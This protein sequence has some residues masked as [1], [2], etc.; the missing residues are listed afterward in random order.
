MGTWGEKPWDNDAAADYYGELFEDTG[1][2]ERVARTLNSEDV[3]PDEWRAAASVVVLL[4]RV[5]V[6]P[7]D[8]YEEHLEL[9]ARRLEQILEG[10]SRETLWRD[11]YMRRR[12]RE[13]VAEERGI[14]LA[15]LNR[16]PGAGDRSPRRWQYDSADDL[17]SRT[18]AEEPGYEG[19]DEDVAHNL[20][21]DDSEEGER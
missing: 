9:A 13:Q 21:E 11:P 17:R 8:S 6:W 5:Y 15:R 10:D 1:L 14:I 19:P 12:F 16:E 3:S 4:G 18:S 7:I 20:P 2:A